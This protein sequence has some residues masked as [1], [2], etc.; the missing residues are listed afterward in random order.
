MKLKI[1]LLAVLTLVLGF[2]IGILV[3]AKLRHN[4]LRPV[5]TSVSE[6]Y[7]REHLYRVIDPDSQQIEKLDIIIREYGKNFH[8]L[9]SDYRQSIDSLM[10]MQWK[11]IRPVLSR[12]QIKRLEE[13]EE[14]RREAMKE[15][16]NKKRMDPDKRFD[17]SRDR[18]RYHRDRDDYS[19]DPDR[20]K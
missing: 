11:E 4:R 13:M 5:R 8:E 12:D 17:R 10:D 2:I 6:R 3:S 7:F 18:D 14:K 1:T 9:S 20:R 16:R 15:F 19:R